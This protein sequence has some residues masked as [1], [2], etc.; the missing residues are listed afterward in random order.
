[1]IYG[2]ISFFFTEK[3][4]VTVEKFG[5]ELLYFYFLCCMKN[6]FFQFR[7]MIK[8]VEEMLG[9]DI[10]QSFCYWKKMSYNV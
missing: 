5:F 7:V 4:I 1:M 9:I 10:R 8:E 6:C 3:L 2:I